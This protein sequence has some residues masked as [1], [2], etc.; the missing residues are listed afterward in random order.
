VPE[1]VPDPIEHR[2]PAP[3]ATQAT[4]FLWLGLLCLLAAAATG[5]I[6][7]VTAAGAGAS[8]QTEWIVA[9]IVLVAGCILLLAQTRYLLWRQAV[10][11]LETHPLIPAVLKKPDAAARIARR[12]ELVLCLVLAA[13]AAL[14]RIAPLLHSLWYDELWTLAFMRSGP[15][16]AVTH[17]AGYNNHLLNSLLGSLCLRAYALVSGGPAEG[18]MLALL[19]RLPAF[20]FGIGAVVMLY[21]AARDHLETPAAAAAALLLAFSPMAIDLSAQTRGYSALIFFAIA[22][23]Y[24]LSAALRD[25]AAY[26]WVGWLLCAVLG[27]FAHLYFVLVV[28]TDALFLLCLILWEATLHE[29]RLR[30]RA[31]FEQSVMMALAWAAL[32][33]ASYAGVWR[34]FLNVEERTAALSPMA[35]AHDILVPTLQLW[36][37]VPQRERLVLF[38]VVSAVCVAL[39]LRYL[40]QRAPGAA[41]VLLGLRGEVDSHGGER[42]QKSCR[43]C[44]SSRSASS[45]R[46]RRISS[47]RA[48]SPSRFLLS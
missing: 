35:R 27:T 29:N 40:A 41:I 2:P 17:Q 10:G 4:A 26:A 14:P 11:I 19:A 1:T 20:A 12:R 38:L 31:L 46:H 48:S 8:V 42:E 36:G 21:I 39:G 28:A 43:S 13:V 23:A 9:L 5:I 32:A 7:A 45:R 6:T 30:A 44:S 37:G 47:I 18:A 3:P 24:F 15:V 22:Q 16:Y 33:G 34:T 25:T